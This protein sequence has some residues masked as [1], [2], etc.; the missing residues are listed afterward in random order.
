M[1]ST[2]ELNDIDTQSH[3][4]SSSLGLKMFDPSSRIP[5]PAQ[6]H[7]HVTRCIF[8]AKQGSFL[9]EHGHGAHDTGD[10]TAVLILDIAFLEPNVSWYRTRVKSISMFFSNC[11]QVQP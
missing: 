4:K 9:N 6:H 10:D 2:S 11:S 1:F 5:R 3:M 7:T 8:K